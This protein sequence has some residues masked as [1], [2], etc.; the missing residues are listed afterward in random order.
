MAILKNLK[1]WDGTSQDIVAGLD[2]VEI[3]DGNI[4]RVGSSDELR[5][6]DVRDMGGL[7]AVPGLI[8]AHMHLCLNPEISAPEA[9]DKFT[10]EE[11]LSQ[12][13]TRAG[14]MLAAGITSARDLGGGQ[15]L[16]LEIRDR[17][18]RGDLHG[19][20]LICSGQP[21]TS[22]KGHCHFWG[23]EA[24]DE[25]AAMA[26]IARQIEH[27]VDLIK[28]MATG[29][30]LT[31]GSSP[32]DAQFDADT[33]AAIVEGAGR[34][35]CHVAAHCHGTSGIHNAALAGVTTIE[36]CSWVGAE[37]WA[38]TYDHE[39]SA[40]IVRRGIWVSPTIN[41]G[42]KRRIGNAEYETVIQENYR[43]MREAG[44][45]LIASTDAGIP[46]VFHHQLPLALPVF[47]HFA[48]LTALET[49]RAATSDCADAIGLGAVTGRIAGGLAADMLFTAANPLDDLAA[50]AEPVD[51]MARGR[52]VLGIVGQGT[53]QAVDVLQTRPT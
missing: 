35:G 27:D 36:H 24:A 1:V 8:D 32:A 37:G 52:S 48:G 16:E 51:V 31:K 9:Q 53:G 5:G 47:A 49:L 50:L 18:R 20:R 46:N 4:A 21:V 2:A 43:R 40:E 42:W 10:R 11:M 22:I 28:V 7:Y 6:A 23:G 15:W 26:V 29:G 39:A 13:A 41:L 19:T 38:R 25:E 30:N 44:V 33:L 45:K 34:H 17:I 14:Q 12:M 3:L